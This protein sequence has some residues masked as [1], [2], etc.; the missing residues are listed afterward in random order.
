M[1]DRNCIGSIAT[2]DNDFV[3]KSNFHNC[4]RSPLLYEAGITREKI[5]R[6]V[7]KQHDWFYYNSIIESIPQ[8]KNLLSPKKILIDV[9]GR[10]NA[11]SQKMKRFLW[12]YSIWIQ[13]YFLG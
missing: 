12:F 8:E 11:S 5:H 2:N 6:E 3:V 7:S 4:T 1:I 10:S 9:S 13:D